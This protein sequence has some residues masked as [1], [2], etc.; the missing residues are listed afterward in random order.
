MKNEINSP[1][2]WLF[3]MVY[4]PNDNREIMLKCL[5]RAREMERD[6]ILDVIKRIREERCNDLY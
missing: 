4:N 5:D 3:A 1:V 6:L 2:E